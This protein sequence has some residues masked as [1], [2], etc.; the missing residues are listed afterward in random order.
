V[1]QID[2]S[3][4]AYVQS[5]QQ[6]LLQVA[7]LMCGDLHQA[8]DLLQD[9]LV[10]LAKRWGRLQDQNPDAYVRRTLYHDNVS[11][12]RK[13]RRELLTS[14]PP[15]SGGVL[16]GLAWDEGA[17]LR[18][19]LQRLP[20]GQRCVIVLRFYEDLTEAQ[21]AHTLG[22]TVGTVKSQ[23]HAALRNLRRLLSTPEPARR[24][25]P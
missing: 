11:W 2:P 18:A 1:G 3:F 22:V 20:P 9:A 8:E 14:M 5:R 10:K 15:E 4:A 16:T 7:V 25:R 13:K 6:R 24:Q 19:A 12:W 21:T 17:D 23:T